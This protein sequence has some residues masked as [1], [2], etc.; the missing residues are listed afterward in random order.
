MGSYFQ[1]SGA[2]MCLNYEDEDSIVRFQKAFKEDAK[3]KCHIERKYRVTCLQILMSIY[4]IY[5]FM[6]V[7]MR[8]QPFAHQG[9]YSSLLSFASIQF[10]RS[11]T[12][13]VGLLR[14]G[15]S[16]SQG[17]CLHT[18]HHRHRINAHKHPYL[19]WDSNPQSQLFDQH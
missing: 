15:I 2:L 7:S 17:L 14:W 13:L 11:Y 18:G 5:N 4:R 9:L 19:K 8:F 6:E 1:I 16:P 3:M 10:S 12:Q